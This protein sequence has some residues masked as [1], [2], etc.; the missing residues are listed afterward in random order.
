MHNAGII[1]ITQTWLNAVKDSCVFSYLNYRKISAYRQHRKGGG[2]MILPHPTF[3]TIELPLSDNFPAS[4]DC[5]IVKILPRK[6][7]SSTALQTTA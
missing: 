3:N 1:A 7:Y 5:V 2:V 4:S 6:T